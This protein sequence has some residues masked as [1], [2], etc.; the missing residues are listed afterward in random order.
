MSP[1]CVT[2]PGFFR[3]PG[4]VIVQPADPSGLMSTIEAARFAGVKPVT[5]R[6]GRARGWLDKQGLDQ[7]GYP[8]HSRD[9]VREAE[10]KVRE[11]ALASA[12]PFD[13]RRTRGRTAA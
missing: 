9:A 2:R 5:I 10:R 11:N 12:C 3:V 13:P 8:M 4:Q 7:R 6:Q 1:E